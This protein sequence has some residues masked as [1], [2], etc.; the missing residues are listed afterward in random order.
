MKRALIVAGAVVLLGALVLVSVRSGGRKKGVT[1]YAEA[2]ARRDIE[3]LVKASG[4]LDPRVKVNISAHVVGKIQRLHVEEGDR[5]EAGEPFLELEK[6]AFLALRD[7]TAAQLEIQRSR[8]RQAQVALDDAALK[9]ERMRRL[10]GE[11]IAAPEQ[12][13]AAELQHKSALQSLEQA[14]QGVMQAEAD[15]VKARDDLAKTTIYAPLAGRVIALNAEEGE[16]V[17]SGTMNNPGSVIGTIADLSEILVKVDV[18]ETEI[19]H[20]R[21]GQPATVHVDA[22]P[23]QEYAGRV[24]KIGSSGYSRPQQPD[25][26]FFKVEILLERPD[27]ALRPGMSARAEVHAEK[28]AGALVI[29]IQAVVERPPL[30]DGEDDGAAATAAPAAEEVKVVFVIEDG[31]A[32]QRAV[33]TGL[34]DATGVEIAA[35]LEAG[36]Q[37]VTGPYRVL[38]D[39]KDGDA[40]K[41]G[42]AGEG[43]GRDVKRAGGEEKEG[44]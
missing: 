29:P 32:R 3:R 9:L 6:E 33:S 22:L 16:V 43:G 7:G 14:R 5:I 20:V 37:V 35:G 4:Q 19:V 24:E 17:V 40:V 23:D 36:A 41:V 15:A 30:A 25:V 34:T 8:L 21:P 42:K 26:T 44:D 1:V 27:E 39:L 18:D 31:K 28:S 10:S 13:E 38:K 11:K 2:A 12:L